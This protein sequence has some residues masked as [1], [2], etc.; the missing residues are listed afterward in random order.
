[1][2][3]LHFLLMLDASMLVPAL[4]KQVLIVCCFFVVI[5]A[6]KAVICHYAEGQ[7]TP[8]GGGGGGVLPLISDRCVLRRFLR[9]PARNYQA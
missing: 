4:A 1:M 3:G 7:E 8:G 6:S 5:Q 2:N 9:V